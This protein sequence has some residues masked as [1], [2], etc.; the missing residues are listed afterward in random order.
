MKSALSIAAIVLAI[1]GAAAGLWGAYTAQTA[2]QYQQPFSKHKAIQASFE[3]QIASA[4]KR[5]DEKELERLR[6]S[7][8]QY[9]EGWRESLKIA[10]L[11]DVAYAS[12]PADVDDFSKAAVSL[13][14]QNAIVRTSGWLTHNATLVGKAWFISGEYQ[15]AAR[16]FKLAEDQQPDNPE[17]LI[18]LAR[19]YGYLA[20]H[21]LAG[22]DKVAFTERAVQSARSALQLLHDQPLPVEVDNDQI[23]KSVFELAQQENH[24]NRSAADS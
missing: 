17:N 6:K 12:N 3:K 24:P 21:A 20:A 13:W 11:V 15:K 23:L 8:E 19:A 14:T 2:L 5:S 16:A 18:H 7:Y 4:E 10:T 1:A 22:E 9:E